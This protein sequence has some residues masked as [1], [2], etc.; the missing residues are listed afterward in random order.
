MALIVHSAH[1]LV[2]LTHYRVPHEFHH[3]VTSGDIRLTRLVSHWEANGEQVAYAISLTGEVSE[4]LLV[5]RVLLVD[6]HQDVLGGQRDGRADL[7]DLLEIFVNRIFEGDFLR[8][9]VEEPHLTN[10]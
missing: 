9:G 10:R 5:L 7:T 1:E 8:G 6:I 3:L 4:I 2:C